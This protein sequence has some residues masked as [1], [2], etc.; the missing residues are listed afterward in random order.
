MDTLRG[1]HECA[2]ILE[3]SFWDPLPRPENVSNPIPDRL[4]TAVGAARE[5]IDA[6]AA[7][8]ESERLRKTLVDELSNLRNSKTADDDR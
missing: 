4:I 8:K 5:E 6:L 2:E 1:L 7:E 3:L